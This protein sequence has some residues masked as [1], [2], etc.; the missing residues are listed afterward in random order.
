MTTAKNGLFINNRWREGGGASFASHDPATG[1]ALWRGAAADE[2][3][4]DEAVESARWAFPAWANLALEARLV[5]LKKFQGILEKRSAALAETLARET[6][7][8]LWDARSE[9][10]AATAKLGHSLQAYHE[11]TGEKRGETAQGF[12]PVLR[13]RPHGVAAVYGPYNFPVHLPGGHIL[14]ALLAGNAVILKPSEL[15]PLTAESL[16]RCWEEAELPEGVIQMVQGERETGKALSAHPAIDAVFFTGSSETGLSLHRQCAGQPQKLL[17]LE[18]G[19]NNPLIVHRVGDIDAAVYWTIQSAY[20]TS[21]QRCTCARR[22]I[23]PEGNDAFLQ[24]L[25]AQVER[26]KVGAW[27]ATPEPF[28]GPL[29]HERE[30]KKLLAAQ[31][32]YLS[33]GAKPLALMRRLHEKLPFLSPG[34]IDV[35][36]VREREDREWFGPMLQVIRVRDMEEAVAEA[37]NTRFGLSSGILSDDREAYA[38]LLRGIRAG[39]VNWN[40]PL[41]GSSAILPFGGVGLSGNHRPAAYYAADYCAYPVASNEAEKLALPAHP[42]PGLQ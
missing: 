34:L 22:L 17:A 5:Y 21:G 12:T 30:A 32:S 4:I 42:A 28:M 9:V 20:V 7:K 3:D 2:A 13:H 27:N 11:R 35:T 23:L 38:M 1:E 29:I 10:A 24:A 40:R 31:E 18:L 15:T 8:V 36:E 41:T 6:G 19:G 37:A 16:M 14:P 33:K 26:I 25:I 39:V